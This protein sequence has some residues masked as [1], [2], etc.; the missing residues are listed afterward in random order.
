MLTAAEKMAHWRCS[1][2]RLMLSSW[3]AVELGLIID[4]GLR[5]KMKTNQDVRRPVNRTRPLADSNSAPSPNEAAGT[6][7]QTN[8][9]KTLK[10]AVKPKHKRKV[11]ASLQLN[12]GENLELMYDRVLRYPDCVRNLYFTFLFVLCAVTNAAD[13][14][15]QAEYDTAACP[16]P[17]DEAKLWHG[18]SGPELKQRI[19]KQ[20][21]IR[22][23][24]SSFVFNLIVQNANGGEIFIYILT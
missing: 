18:Q 4:S 9:E 5:D 1:L 16:L 22:F 14:L 19:Q 7:L 20:F 11:K 10:D 15:E 23:V 24:C 3:S 8:G 21:R 13:Y 6:G 12:W 17:F 2:A